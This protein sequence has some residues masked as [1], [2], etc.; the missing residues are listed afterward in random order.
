MAA[1]FDFNRLQTVRNY[2]ATYKGGKGVTESYIYRLIRA[3]R[4]ETVDIDGLIFAVLPTES[5]ST[6]KP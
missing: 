6:P 2:A 4:L 5:A 1:I 3:K